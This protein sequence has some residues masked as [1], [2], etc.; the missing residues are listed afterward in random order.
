MINSKNKTDLLKERGHKI[1]EARLA[2]LDVFL[3]SKL[4]LTAF[5]VQRILGKNNKFK[6]INEATI[7]RT[8]SSFEKSDIIKKI[9]LRRDS[10]YFELNDDHH[11]HIVCTNCGLIEDFKESGEIEKLLEKISLKTSKF[12]SIKEHSLELFGICKECK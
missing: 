5:D 6:G 4:P 9:D 8:I 2:I 3:N 10:V 11:H 12:K 7:Y 1:T